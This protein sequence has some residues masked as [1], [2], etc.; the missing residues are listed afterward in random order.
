MRIAYAD[1]PYVGQAKKHYGK[2]ASYAGEVDHAQLAVSLQ[3]F[4]GW[5]LS[6]SGPS[7]HLVLPLFPSARIGAW[8]KPFAIFKP[9]VNPGYCWEPVLFKPARSGAARAGARKAPTARDWVRV[10]EDLVSGEP[11]QADWVAANITLR[12]GL[13]GVKPPAFCEWLFDLLGAEPT[14][15]FVDMYPGSGAVT[16]AWEARIKAAGREMSDDAVQH[17]AEAYLAYMRKGQP[18]HPENVF[19]FIRW[20]DTKG[21]ITADRRAVSERVSY[22]LMRGK[23][24]AGGE[25]A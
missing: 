24:R 13:S 12:K 25:A 14:D 11:E 23:V 17:Q 18:E 16:R 7:L 5:A 6:A 3:D 10:G 20:A 22:I 1:P 15:E 19:A 4:D 2:E 9:G 8:V 21:L